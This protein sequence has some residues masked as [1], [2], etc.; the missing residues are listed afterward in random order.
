MYV[1]IGFWKYKLLIFVE[2]SIRVPIIV[3][4][5]NDLYNATETRLIKLEQTLCINQ[6]FEQTSYKSGEKY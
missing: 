3:F 2:F 5:N 1:L 6:S 4:S